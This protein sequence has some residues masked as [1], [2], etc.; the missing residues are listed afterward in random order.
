MEESEHAKW[1]YRFPAYID[2]YGG[3]GMWRAWEIRAWSPGDAL[4]SLTSDAQPLYIS[5]RSTQEGG[6]SFGVSPK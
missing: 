1:V 5:A 3:L 6:A 2:R 4:I